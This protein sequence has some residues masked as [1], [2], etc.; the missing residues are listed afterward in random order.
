[1]ETNLTPTNP[2]L[3]AERE[4][5]LRHVED[6]ARAARAASGTAPVVDRGATARRRRAGVFDLVTPLL[7][8]VLF[9][10]MLALVAMGASVR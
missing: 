5:A 4:A 9:A 2:T 8:V 3:V 6:A 1:M 7:F 10:G